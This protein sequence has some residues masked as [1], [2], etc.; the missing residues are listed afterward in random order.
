MAD[1]GFLNP[2]GLLFPCNTWEHMS[3]AIEI[4]ESL[5][6]TFYSGIKAEEYLQKQ[7]WIVVRQ[8]DVYGLIGIYDTETGKKYHLSS[9]QKEWLI[10]HY[11]N[12]SALKR[13]YVDEL[14]NNDR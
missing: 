5:G 9:K 10:A 3:K 6:K 11:E 1:I 7:G 12:M 2:E 14:F 13:K 4:A 8:S